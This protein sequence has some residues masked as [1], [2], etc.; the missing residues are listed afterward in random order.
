MSARCRAMLGLALALLGAGM[1]RLAAQEAGPLG[2]A[3]AGIAALPACDRA[4]FA[5]ALDVGHTPEQPG[6]MS[7]RGTPEFVFNLLLAERIERALRAAG[8]DRTRLLITWGR[9]KPSLFARVSQA[10]DVAADLYLSVHHDAVPQQ[11][12]ET[13]EHEGRALEYSDRFKGHSIFVSSDHANYKTSLAFARQIG[14]QMR[15]RGL[16]YTSHYTEPFMGK[17]RRQ[18]VDAEAG[19]YRFDELVV[20]RRTAMPAV[21]LE[22]GMIVHRD[23]ELELA[24]PARH[25]LI[26]AS[27]VAAVE[28]LCAARPAEMSAMRRQK[29]APKPPLLAGASRIGFPTRKVGLP[30]RK[31]SVP[32]L[33]GRD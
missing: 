13:W 31:V 1:E 6:A 11:F 23:E 9:A 5:V 29:P 15:A 10:N 28:Q 33:P 19:V 32:I 21:L 27:V 26:A 25:E 7:A 20:L 24:G 12:K 22:G 8:F 4:R 3:A 17:R 18:L 14:L 2:Q 16:A 30:T